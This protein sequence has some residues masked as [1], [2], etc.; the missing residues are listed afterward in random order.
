MKRIVEDIP[1]AISD[2]F[3]EKIKTQF[4]FLSLGGLCR[5]QMNLHDMFRQSLK[6]PVLIILYVCPEKS[7]Y[8][9]SM[10]SLKNVKK[11]FLKDVLLKLDPSAF[12]AA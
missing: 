6:R 9:D 12:T 2:V 5:I 1:F 7:R 10:I 4:S 11:A 3:L 8:H